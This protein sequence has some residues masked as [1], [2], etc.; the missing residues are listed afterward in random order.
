MKRMRSD[1]DTMS[2]SL[3]SVILDPSSNAGSQSYTPT[4]WLHASGC[5]GESGRFVSG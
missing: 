3:G 4:L 2:N 5:V 1:W